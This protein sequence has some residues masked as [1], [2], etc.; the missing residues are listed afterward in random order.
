MKI[1]EILTQLWKADL[2]RLCR[3]RELRARGTVP[4][5]LE[6]LARSYRGD[7][8][9]VMGDLRR[10][11]LVAIGITL[12]GQFDL[13]SGWR[14]LR[15]S[16][17]RR[18]FLALVKKSSM[19]WDGGP[20]DYS[21]ALYSTSGVAANGDV[22]RFDFDSLRTDAQESE[23]TTVISA[24]F[25]LGTLS[26]LLGASD[27]EIRILLNGSG[28]RRLK[29][30]VEELE[31]LQ[32][33]LAAHSRDAE[34]RLGFADGIFHTK[35]YL[36]EKRGQAVAWLGSANATAAGLLG[37][38]EE[39]L[40]RLSPA[41][42]AVLEYAERAWWRASRLED[43]CAPITSLTAFYR[44][45]MLYYKP[46]A[47]LQ[48]T[49]NPFR[50]L[51]ASLPQEERDK[52]TPFRSD[53]AETEVGIGAFSI[54]RVLERDPERETDRHEQDSQAED[55]AGERLYVRQYAV[56][57]CYGYWV[58]EKFVDKVDDLLAKASH[59]KSVTLHHLREWLVRREGFIVE[60]YQAYLSTAKE[61]M[62]SRG[63]AWS[64]HADGQLFTDTEPV[65]KHIR[66]LVGKLSDEK[67]LKR[68]CQ[69]YVSS[70]IPELWEDGAAL[71]A[72][73]S[74]F[75]EWLAASSSGQ[76][77]PKAAVTILDAIGAYDEDAEGIRALLAKR[78]A[79]PEWYEDTFLDIE[80]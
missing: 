17:M 13:P 70:E 40:G 33:A 18:V 41:P 25:S 68:Y 72:F 2:V 6:R 9:A 31:G 74:S 52:I 78:V 71:E 38:N 59:S 21:F 5:L 11:D 29:A 19:P 26:E 67:R 44:T 10:E 39:V 20:S 1:R 37:H 61:A 65:R 45:G 27:G 36:F 43:C 22:R 46:Y 60:A 48:K 8:E 12:G 55:P 32:T 35:L 77:R 56:E 53:F 23:R 24:Y 58:S 49:F 62:D 63:V 75:F 50:R 15:V 30:Q 14:Q 3:R 80:S 79:D 47:Q 57:T 51:M 28:G 7:F 69:A 34:I 66:S 42:S 4:D 54:D 64:G 73:E 76:R 16:E